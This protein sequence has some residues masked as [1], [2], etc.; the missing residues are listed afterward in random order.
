MSDPEMKDPNPTTFEESLK[1]I[2]E[3]CDDIFLDWCSAK[4]ASHVN[5]ID[6]TKR[7]G[8]TVKYL[9][10]LLEDE[11]GFR[12]YAIED[13]WIQIR[14][15]AQLALVSQAETPDTITLGDEVHEVSQ[16][17]D[18]L[19]IDKQK[20]YGPKNITM[21]GG[22]GVLVRSNDKLQRL[23]NL[24]GGGSDPQNE[25]IRDTWMDLRNYA[26]IAIML[27][28]GQFDLPLIDDIDQAYM[29]VDEAKGEDETVASVV[30]EKRFEEIKEKQ[31]ELT[32]EVESNKA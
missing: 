4:Q 28:R 11:N 9:T 31:E 29:G 25:S 2:T 20:D 26:Q 12:G 14:N 19:L 21:F 23:K 16:E 3:E 30:N 27:H 32:E 1:E 17:C 5:K 15:E 24:L 13:S 18:Q 7:V 22:Y 10:K 8:H 6:V